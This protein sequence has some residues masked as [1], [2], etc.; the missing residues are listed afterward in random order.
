MNAM[1]ERRPIIDG[2]VLMP[3]GVMVAVC[4]VL[5]GGFRWMD[6]RFTALEIQVSKL[7]A[8]VED[9]WTVSEQAL[10]AERLKSG[11]PSISV[12]TVRNR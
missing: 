9:N 4:G 2:K 5:F 3:V 12:P 7:Q 8:I 11:N 6:A 10:W 1:S